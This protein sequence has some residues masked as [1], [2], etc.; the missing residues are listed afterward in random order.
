MQRFFEIKLRNVVFWAVV[1]IVLWVIAV[2]IYVTQNFH[3]EVNE[4][5]KKEQ[6]H[7]QETSADVKTS[8]VRNLHL[9]AGVPNV[10]E[11]SARVQQL[12]RKYSGLNP[13]VPR[14]NY[15]KKMLAD[16]DV[17]NLDSYLELSQRALNVDL[18]FVVNSAGDC[19][20]AS[21]RDA[22][23]T[24]IG[25]SYSDREWFKDVRNGH[26]GMQYAMGKTT[27]IPG[28]FFATP[29]VIDGEFMGAVVAKVDIPTLSYLTS[30]A[31]AYVAD[32]NGVIIMA[33][34]PDMEMMAI[35]DA[36]VSKLPGKTRLQLYRRLRFE[37][38]K[39]GPW[40]GYASE[41]LKQI[42]EEKN[43]HVLVSGELPE[44]GLKVFAEAELTEWPTLVLERKSNLIQYA[45]IGG[46][47]ILVG[48]FLLLYFHSLREAK[49]R[50]EESEEQFRLMVSGVKDYAIVMLNTDGLVQDWNAG[51]EQI[52]G[53]SSEEIVGK[54]F[55]EFYSSEDIALGIP[56]HELSVA[57]TEGSYK[58]EG[59]R[60][61]KDGTRFIADVV[62]TSSWDINGTLRGFSHVA[63]DITKR[64][65]AEASLI[66]YRDN[67]EKVVAEQT[68]SLRRAKDAAEKANKAKSEFLANMSHEIRTPMNAIIGMSHLVLN[69]N[70][71]ARQ[72]DYIKKI[73]GS[74]Q[75]LLSII[76]AILDLSKIEAGKLTIERADFELESVLSNVASLISEKTAEKDLELVFDIDRNVPSFLNGDSLR[77]GQILINYANNAIKFTEQG[78]VVIAARVLEETDSDVH[79]RF[80]V[81]D[82]GIGI[83]EEQKSK[84]FQT[85][86]Q[87]DSSTSRKYGGTGLGLAISKQLASL[88]KGEVGVESEVGKGSTF[89]FTVWL[90]KLAGKEASLQPLPDVRGRC[91]LVVDDNEV[92]RNV[93]DEML[94]SLS[95]KVDQ[96]PCGKDAVAAV[97]RAAVQGNPYEIVFL[98]WRMPEMD[99][100]ETAHAIQELHLEQTPHLMMV[101]AYGREEVVKEAKEAG[102]E[103]TLVKPVTPSMLFDT[104]MRVLGANYD[105]AAVPDREVPSASEAL[106]V[107]RGASILLVE[108][109][110]FNQEVAIGLLADAGFEVEVANN[111][112]RAVEMVKQQHYDIVLMDMHMPVMDGV[113]ATLEIRKDAQFDQLP[114][115]AMTANA[116]QQD[117]DKCAQAGMNDYLTKPIDPDE[118]FRT[119]LKWIKPRHTMAA[120]QP[121]RTVAASSIEDMP[122]IE[123]LDVELGLQRVL[124]K[125]SLY[126]NMLRKY[127]AN[128]ENV[129]TEL[130][131]ALDIGDRAAA[132]L[133]AHSSKAVNG[134]IGATRLQ[135][136]AESL[137]DMLR[138]GASIDAIRA[139]TDEF[140][141]VQSAM[142][143]ELR[144]S[145]PAQE[146]SGQTTE[147]SPE[148]ASEVLGR[149]KDLLSNDDSE[150]CDVLEE[151]FDQLRFVLG[152]ET[153]PKVDKAIKQFDFEKALQLIEQASPQQLS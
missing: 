48:A 133:L 116:M 147:V 26:D 108:D 10:L 17:K 131:A 59:R 149:L 57:A 42:R 36:T 6:L 63:Q 136:I 125:K 148:Q 47:V 146:T 144:A 129:V 21:T 93:M 113:N 96:V 60:V 25:T 20:S 107:I 77:L 91:V 45:S 72:R 153:F 137:E 22:A 58:V 50:V 31:D 143:A 127:I 84:L 151:N 100:I 79:L 15:L 99:G 104:T 73:Q 130:R 152:C 64:K 120:K 86:Q 41:S 9:V 56:Q 55:S 44:F 65:R 114:I 11:Q 29:I 83:S 2:W 135:E 123:G 53:F 71:S 121:E 94:S 37:E 103:Y 105:I 43:P 88:M 13:D 87:A 3:G 115:V 112:Q 12:V 75:H 7:A 141:V 142:I 67:L 109:N 122:V 38:L 4:L 27:H 23:M 5:V 18:I 134:N 49:R 117:K 62:I 70:L 124:G 111:G 24:P 106:S 97:Q 39:I 16:P 102:L 98:D 138:S 90:G 118:L 76:N 150:A 78:E 32:V 82:T 101:T 92:A 110:E 74:G 69:T 51:A 1:L 19:I 68:D 34:E 119:L 35:P 28:L 61:R 40:N 54:S 126:L 132:E 66:K 33:H 80:E 139:R 89:W 46:F 145:V 140:A 8:I 52:H 14:A 81:R 128:Q 30:Q 95:F 85:F